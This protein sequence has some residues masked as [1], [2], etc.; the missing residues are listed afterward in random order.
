MSIDARG[1]HECLV[2][3]SDADLDLAF[4]AVEEMLERYERLTP[5]TRARLIRLSGIFS[6]TSLEH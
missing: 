2:W 4:R 1:E 6:G 5:E 3:L